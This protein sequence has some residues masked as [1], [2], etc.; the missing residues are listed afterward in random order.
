MNGSSCM[1]R[2]LGI[3]LEGDKHGA[4]DTLR[5]AVVKAIQSDPVTWC[6]PVLG[7]DPE[8]YCERMLKP[9]TWGGEPCSLEMTSLRLA[10]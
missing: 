6:E 7:M 10:C 2:A 3:A 9:S 8:R 5:K 4:A 1:F